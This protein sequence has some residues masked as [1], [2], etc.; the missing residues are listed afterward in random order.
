MRGFPS[1]LALGE[2]RY[3]RYQGVGPKPVLLRCND[4]VGTRAIAFQLVMTPEQ[5]L[6]VAKVLPEAMLLVTSEGEILASNKPAANLLGI[7]SKDLVGKWLWDLLVELPE[8]VVAYLQA[9]AKSRQLVLGSLTL[10]SPLESGKAAI[11]RAEGAVF[12]PWSPEAP[13]LVLL[14]LELRSAAN[15]DFT[16]LNQK[17]EELTQEV[18]Q[19]QQAQT[20]LAQSHAELTELLEKFQQTQLQLV[21]TEKMSS[22]GQLVAGIAHEINNP[23]NFI[24]GNLNHAHQ[25]FNDLLGLVKLYQ[26][27]Y[28]EP[29]QAIQDEIDTIDLA[30]LQQ[31]LD[32]VI[33]SMQTGANRICEIVKSLR[34]FSRLDE[35][36]V[37]QVN[38]HEGIDSTLVILQS[39][40]K[41]TTER[42]AIEVMKDYGDVPLIDCYAGQ[43][44][45]VFMNLLGNAI[46]AL[47]ESQQQRQSGFIRIEPGQIR[48][49]TEVCR[50]GWVAIVIS[51]NGPGIPETVVQRIFD[52]FFTT[53]PVGQGTGLGLS[54]SYQI[55]TEKHGGK[56]S[57][58]SALGKGTIFTIEIPI[59]RLVT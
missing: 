48:I 28:P 45:Q 16:L 56:L 4:F 55:V 53:K 1:A 21:Q 17:I 43:L 27:H 31:D 5:F 59:H 22:L 2:G 37:K 9:C 6:Q 23:V 19:R 49:R 25:Y 38:I 32:N 47:E 7:K 3:G 50:A 29:A 8:Q 54:I 57:C 46:D 39:R 18:H 36:E 58:T 33:N 51:D 52:P 12:R 14:R 20:E 35:A 24:Y 15:A 40:L 34:M 26:E 30:F 10:S 41:A 42:P 13:A 11:C 44:N